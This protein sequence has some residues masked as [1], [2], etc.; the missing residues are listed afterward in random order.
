MPGMRLEIQGLRKSFEKDEVLRGVDF[1]FEEGKIYGLLG[2]NGAGKTTFFRCLIRDLPFE[3]GEFTLWRAERGEKLLSDEVA[4]VTSEPAVPEFLT[5][6]EFLKYFVDANHPGLGREERE[7]LLQDYFESLSI[8]ERDR[9]KLLNEYSHG[10][11]NK[12]L[13]LANLLLERPILLLD[14]PLTSVDVV[15][16]EEIKVV[17]R[18]FKEQQITILSTHLLDLALDLC[19]E[20]VLLQNGKIQALPRESLDQGA[21]RERIM[22][23]LRHEERATHEEG[24]TC[25]A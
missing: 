7:R 16:A 21:Y 15:A 17:L 4:F 10:M 9:H 19:D 2:R 3:A 18:Q 25:E 8:A 11:K 13:M 6:Y 23:S 22:G 1:T 14:E 24:T 12:L 5:G 20:I